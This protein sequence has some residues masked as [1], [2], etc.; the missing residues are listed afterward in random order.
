[1]LDFDFREVKVAQAIIANARH[2]ILVC[3]STKFERTAPVRI[4]H[5]SQV[6]SFIT[7]RCPDPRI[8]GICEESDV[9]LVEVAI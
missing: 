2:V 9:R 5:I 3:D 7:D 4:G 1:L 6:D 8:R